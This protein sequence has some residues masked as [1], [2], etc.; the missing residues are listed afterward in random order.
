MARAT[1]RRGTGS[2]V[3]LVSSVLVIC[4]SIAIL[5]AE[6]S[7]D[8]NIRGPGDALWWAV[9]TIT[10][11]GY[12]DK[13][14]VT[15]EGRVVAAIL[16]IGG[17][18]LFGTFTAWVASLL[19]KSGKDN[20]SETELLREMKLLREHLERLEAKMSGVQVAVPAQ[21]GTAER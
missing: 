8:S 20:S 17:V 16:M 14:P 7:A 18:G 12:G 6:T 11:V 19:L 5:G 13:Y 21:F 4:S 15:P 10:T 9:A 3:V 2:F 1:G